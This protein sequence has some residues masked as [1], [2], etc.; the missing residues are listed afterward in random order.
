VTSSVSGNPAEVGDVRP[1]SR[2][3]GTI[4]PTR[5][6]LAVLAAVLLPACGGTTDPATPA[7]EH[8]G[9]DDPA[10]SWAL[11]DAEPAI[12]V[13]AGARVTLLVVAEGRAWQVG[14]TSACNTYGGTVV[15]DGTRWRTT[16]YGMTD[17]GCE[18]RH[19]AAE[20]A[21]LDALTAVDTW[22]RPSEEQLVLSGRGAT[23]RFAALPPVP[24]AEL[25]GVTW[26]LDGIVTAAGEDATHASPAAGADEATLHLDHDGSVEVST[27]CRTF[28][29]EWVETGDEVLL[30]TF[31]ER[32]DTPNVGG[33]GALLCDEAVVAQEDHVLSVLG[34][35]FSAEVDGAHLTLTSRDGLGLTYLRAED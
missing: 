25:T 9:A 7:V 3:S 21:Y 16:G 1:F 35:G 30:T 31:G 20:R 27:G 28:S 14:G 32:G 2:R 5:L 4:V 24:T 8:A 22:A 34:D 33:D 11:V 15:T 26:V 6:L 29:G 19:M 17:M 18:E 13:P 23:L 12:D 10:G